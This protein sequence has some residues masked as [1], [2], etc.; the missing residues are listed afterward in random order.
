MTTTAFRSTATS[1]AGSPTTRRSASRATAGT[2]CR[3]VD[4]HDREAVDRAI[5]AAKAV[6]RSAFADL[7][8]DSHRRRARPTRP[9]T[10]E[11]HGAALGEK[12]IAATRAA[13]GWNYAAVRDPAACRT[14]R[15][16]HA[17]AALQPRRAGRRSSPRTRAHTPRARAR[18]R[19][20]H[21]R[22]AARRFRGAR[23]RLDGEDEGEGRDDRDPQGFAECRSRRWRRCLPEL[24]GGSADLA[25]SNLTLWS[26]SRDDRARLQAATTFTTACASSAWPRS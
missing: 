7:L 6:D 2:S 24:V 8:Q 10:H 19:A 3:D 13:I 18:I 21:E 11:A 22:R 17:S 1:R 12:E 9:G 5:V 20:P 15:G 26:G 16:T 25:G 4:G 23:A 14:R